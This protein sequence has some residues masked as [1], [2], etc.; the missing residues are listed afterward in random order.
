MVVDVSA[1]RGRFCARNLSLVQP[2][3]GRNLPHGVAFKIAS[4]ASRVVE[5]VA[6]VFSIRI[7]NGAT[8]FYFQKTPRGSR[9]T[10]RYH[11]Q[12]RAT[13]LQ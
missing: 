13:Q 12:D 10:I 5:L 7:K 8:H 2:S 4:K 3:N 1:L 6:A 9:K 11:L